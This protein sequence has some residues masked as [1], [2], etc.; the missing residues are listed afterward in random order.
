[1]N[2][3][4]PK[5]PKSP[6]SSRRSTPVLWSLFLAGVAAV[7]VVSYSVDAGQGVAVVLV[8]GLVALQ[9]RVALVEME[10]RRDRGPERIT[11]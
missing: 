3:K 11:A 4:S 8:A 2:T 10:R 9:A 7:P 6:Q 5:S 1:M